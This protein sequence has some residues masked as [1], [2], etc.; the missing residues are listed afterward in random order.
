[1]EWVSPGGYICAVRR[2]SK[3]P[4]GVHSARS[5]LE[6]P[7]LVLDPALYYPVV[8]FVPQLILPEDG[9]GDEVA[10]LEAGAVS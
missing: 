3:N 10:G 6:Q 9:P 7:E 8:R 5:L 4:S 1:M 2:I